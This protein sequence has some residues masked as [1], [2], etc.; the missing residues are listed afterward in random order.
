[1]IGAGHNN[2]PGAGFKPALSTPFYASLLDWGGKTQHVVCN[3]PRIKARLH[4]GQ[5]GTYLWVANPTR[6][7]VPVRL[8]VSEGWGNF[9]NS[10]SLWGAQATFNSGCIELTA[11]ARDMTVLELT[12]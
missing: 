4:T 9:K 5:G 7:P 3:D 12:R 10:R 8:E 6:Q 2:H 11:P 1:M